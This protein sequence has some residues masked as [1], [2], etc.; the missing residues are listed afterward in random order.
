MSE[1]ED[2][3]AHKTPF[4]EWKVNKGNFAAQ[5]ISHEV[6]IDLGAF[7]PHMPCAIPQFYY[8]YQAN[9]YLWYFRVCNFLDPP[10][11]QKKIK[12]MLMTHPALWD[13]Y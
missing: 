7:L 10:P 3:H 8:S 13:P 5:Q 12:K 11:R 2:T 9:H 4:T 1:S 6:K